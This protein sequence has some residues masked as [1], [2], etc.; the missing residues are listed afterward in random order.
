MDWERIQGL[1]NYETY[2]KWASGAKQTVN[3]LS[4][5]LDAQRKAHNKIIVGYGA[6]AKGN[7]LLNF[8]NINMD[9]I[10]DDNPLKQHKYTPGMS[11]PVVPVEHLQNFVGQ[12]ICFVPLAWNF[13]DEIVQRIK[14]VRNNSGDV[15][16]R[17][18]PNIQIQ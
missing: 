5:V 14:R 4:I 1:Y 3:D 10:I 12:D 6:P 2:K 13:F 8:G 9:F 11:I 16:V 18:F 7:T 17:Y 15:F